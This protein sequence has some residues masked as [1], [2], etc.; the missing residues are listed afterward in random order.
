MKFTPSKYNLD[1]FA[2]VKLGQ[3][4]IVIDAVPGSGKTTTIM[5]SIKQNIRWIE[6]SLSTMFRS[7]KII[8]ILKFILLLVISIYILI[9]PFLIFVNIYLSIFGL[10]FLISQYLSRIRKCIFYKMTA[11]NEQK[12][13][14]SFIF[15][16]KLIFYTYLDVLIRIVAFCEVIFFKK[17]YKKRKNLI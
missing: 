12:V 3:N 2:E 15:F 4:N 13:N 6:N 8:S 9:S 11:N 16:I 17:K 5:E 1:I 14:L 10:F 7:K